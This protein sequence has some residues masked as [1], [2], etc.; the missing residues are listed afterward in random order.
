MGR[1]EVGDNTNTTTNKQE[2]LSGV[3]GGGQ[4]LI[5]YYSLP[6]EQ[7]TLTG[8]LGTNRIRL[9]ANAHVPALPTHPGEWP[10]PLLTTFKCSLNYISRKPLVI[11]KTES[12]ITLTHMSASHIILI[13]MSEPQTI[14]F[15]IKPS[16]LTLI[17]TPLLGPIS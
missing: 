12:L 1:V 4:Q 14:T 17:T 2:F 6:A 7:P 16:L 9:I 3:R 13:L 15:T 11:G 5:A 10:T 8:K